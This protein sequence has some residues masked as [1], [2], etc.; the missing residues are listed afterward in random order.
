[1]PDRPAPRQRLCP[2]CGA[3]L[4]SAAQAACT[5]CGFAPAAGIV[6]RDAPPQTRGL[7]AVA[8][9]FGTRWCFGASV[10]GLAVI[11]IYY[12]DITAAEE[13]GRT[14]SADMFT[15]AAYRI[16]GKW[17]ALG[18][19]F[20]FSILFFVAGLKARRIALEANHEAGQGS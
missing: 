6:R 12:F 16:G 8:R 1:M 20:A 9:R 11:G 7:E 17:A 3:L 14:F 10:L 18:L 2:S 15:G 5:H 19:W 4:P 13:S